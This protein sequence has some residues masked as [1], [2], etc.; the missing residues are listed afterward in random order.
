MLGSYE[1]TKNEQAL[2]TDLLTVRALGKIRYAL[3]SLKEKFDHSLGHKADDRLTD[4]HRQ[5]LA[6]PQVDVEY[7]HKLLQSLDETMQVVKD[8][9]GRKEQVG[10]AVDIEI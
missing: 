7:V 9:A 3:L 6:C 1:V 8:A 10:S 2:V 4:K 5:P